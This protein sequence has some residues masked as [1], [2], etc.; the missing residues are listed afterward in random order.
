MGVGDFR[1][2]FLIIEFVVMFYLI[3]RFEKF[4]EDALPGMGVHVRDIMV[5]V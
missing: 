5:K 4:V 2:V 1:L 3:D